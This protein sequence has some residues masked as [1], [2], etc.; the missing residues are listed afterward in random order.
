MPPRR[1]VETSDSESDALEAIPPPPVKK[2]SIKERQLQALMA[3]CAEATGVTP[4]Q[5]M[6]GSGTPSTVGARQNTV[7]PGQGV[8]DDAMPTEGN[9]LAC[10]KVDQYEAEW[11]ASREARGARPL[12]EVKQFVIDITPPKKK[13]P[14]QREEPRAHKRRRRDSESESESFDVDSD[15]PSLPAR[16]LRGK[17]GVRNML[18]DHWKRGK[19]HRRGDP[20]LSERMDQSR[21]ETYAVP[22]PIDTRVNFST[23]VAGLE[24]QTRQVLELIVMPVVYPGLYC[25]AEASHGVLF[26]GPPGCGKT[27][28]ARAMAG[29]MQRR[30]GCPVTFFVNK[31]AD[32]LAK[33]VGE[34]ERNLRQLFARAQ[35]AQPS[36]IFFDEIDGLAPVRNNDHDQV[37]AS[38][39]STLLALLEGVRS[40]GQVFVIAATNRPENVD[41]ALRRPG[42]FD[43]EFFFSPPDM[44]A[45][46]QML[47]IHTRHWPAESVPKKAERKRVAAATEGY[48][49]A[50]MRLLAQQARSAAVRRSFP[51]IYRNVKRIRCDEDQFRICAQD[52][53]AALASVSPS[54]QRPA[55]AHILAAPRAHL[56]EL[57]RADC[58]KACDQVRKHLP[59]PFA[60][61]PTAIYESLFPAPPSAA[62]L[63]IE[64]P[65]PMAA[66]EVAVA[67][68]AV[69]PRS[70]TYTLSSRNVLPE[71]GRAVHQALDILRG[72]NAVLLL[73]RPELWYAQLDPRDRALLVHAV[74]DCRS[75]S[76]LV[77]A[78][79]GVELDAQLGHGSPFDAACE[80]PGELATALYQH[81]DLHIQVGLPPEEARRLFF[82][83]LRKVICRAPPHSISDEDLRDR[84]PLDKR[85][86]PIR[87]ELSEEGK[88]ERQ[89]ALRE[90]RHENHLRRVMLRK[91]L[92]IL[93]DK[94]M[95]SRREPPSIV[96]STLE[97]L[98]KKVRP[99]LED[100]VDLDAELRKYA[101]DPQTPAYW[102]D[103]LDNPALICTV[104]QFSDGVSD[105]F[106]MYEEFIDGWDLNCGR[107]LKSKLR[108]T[109]DFITEEL[110]SLQSQLVVQVEQH[111][112]QQKEALDPAEAARRGFAEDGCPACGLD[113]FDKNH[114]AVKCTDETCPYNQWHRQCV[115]P[116]V[117]VAGA[118]ADSWVCPKCLNCPERAAGKRK[119]PKKHGARRHEDE[120]D[121]DM[122]E[123]LECPEQTV[124]GVEG[125]AGL[126]EQAATASDGLSVSQLDKIWVHVSTAA[127][128][129]R[130]EVDKS[131]L[132]AEISPV[133]QKPRDFCAAG[134]PKGK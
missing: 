17:R 117:P 2:M 116:E 86:V 32:L 48:S 20:F 50:D 16:D 130:E 19:R 131:D 69:L 122:V 39:V 8:D 46:E 82:K 79:F 99:E 81:A 31:G 7:T 110:H 35:A 119:A 98:D 22:V 58:T 78:C 9:V 21:T 90:Q 52:W 43:K 89:A 64:S 68:S 91:E 51:E 33:Y 126:L 41:P 133:L 63:V 18:S 62:R 93:A 28:V 61:N 120:G 134:V 13:P 54:L 103:F 30:L 73:L 75:P 24:E 123:P 97:E 76:V 107:D 80:E 6:A 11:Q 67:C 57:V 29:E 70:Q 44:N 106:R 56:N 83:E 74:R 111:W 27:L 88:K 94:L 37:H 65:D 87:R 102:A 1:H 113:D 14:K 23:A 124:E 118:A 60:V 3:N 71:Q 40:R 104:Q 132:L 36:I 47:Q 25:D 105:M 53:D 100:T 66:Q 101:D 112:E 10:L 34:S 42:R 109:Q 108:T 5:L 125:V 114:P 96:F 92:R 55:D 38:V 15:A 95:T 128:H 45:R 59:A 12:K 4:E 77:V 49:G 85:P 84:L 127:F 72:G 121:Q 26:T 115:M 129:H